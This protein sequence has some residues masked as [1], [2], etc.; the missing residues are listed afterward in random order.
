MKIY[1]KSGDKGETGLYGGQRVRKDS[2]RV[3]AY[4]T[5]DELNSF[6]SIAKLHLT[7]PETTSTITNLQKEL[8]V[9][10]AD[11]AT[12]PHSKT[13]K[14]TPRIT[15][16]HVENLETLIDK[17]QNILPPQKHF[18]LPGGCPASSA[19]EAARSVCRRA[20]RRLWTVAKKE[21]VNEQ[22]LIYLNRLSDFLYVLARLINKRQ[23]VPETPWEPNTSF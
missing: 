8:F 20:E 11:I 17:A 22:A 21:P 16:A 10:G 15:S 7:E 9:L 23:G 2:T 18:Y 3:E 5:V 14:K 6:L 13:A 12:P 19:L 4:G 1:T